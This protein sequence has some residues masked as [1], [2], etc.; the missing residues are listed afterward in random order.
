MDGTNR[1]LRGVLLFVLGVNNEHLRKCYKN[2]NYFIDFYIRMCYIYNYRMLHDMCIKLRGGIG[3]KR[4]L[5]ALF[6]CVLFA[7]VLYACEGVTLPTGITTLVDTTGE[8]T[9]EVS[10]IDVTTISPTTGSP[11]L[12]SDTSIPTT[13]VPTSVPTTDMS[14]ISSDTLEPTTTVP[15]TQAPTTEPVTTVPTTEAPTTEPVTTVPT[16][17]EPTSEPVTTVPTTDAPTTEPVTTIPT[18]EEPTTEPVTTVPTTTIETTQTTDIDEDYASVSF[19]YPNGLLIETIIVLKGEDVTPPSDPQYPETDDYTYTF[20]GWDH[21]MHNVQANLVVYAIY[22]A[23]YKHGSGEFDFNDFLPLLSSISGEN[24]SHEEAQEIVDMILHMTG[25]QSEEHVYHLL[26][27]IPDLRDSLFN[28]TTNEAFQLW[29]ESTK[30]AGFTKELMTDMII[31]AILQSVKDQLDHLPNEELIAMIA[32]LNEGVQYHQLLMDGLLLEVHDYCVTYTSDPDTCIAYYDRYIV[33]HERFIEYQEQMWRYIGDGWIQDYLYFSL[34]PTVEQYIYFTYVDIDPSIAEQRLLSLDAMIDGLPESTQDHYVTLIDMYIAVND[35]YHTN[36]AAIEAQLM[37]EIDTMLPEP[38]PVAERLRD[39]F[40]EHYLPLLEDTLHN[41]QTIEEFESILESLILEAAFLSGTYEWLRSPDGREALREVVNALYDAIDANLLGV[42]EPIYSLI[43][44]LINESF[45]PET[46]FDSET[47]CLYIDELLIILDRFEVAFTQYGLTDIIADAGGSILD[48]FIRSLG[49]EADEQAH[50]IALILPKIPEYLAM[51]DETYHELHQFLESIDVEKVQMAFLVL[52]QMESGELGPFEQVILVSQAIDLILNDGSIDMT[53]IMDY[54]I[55]IYYDVECFFAADAAHVSLVKNAFFSNMTRILELAHDISFYDPLNLSIMEMNAIDEMMSRVSSFMKVFEMGFDYALAPIEFGFQHEDFIELVSNLFGYGMELEEAEY[56]IGMLMEMFEIE[57]E[58]E[59]YYLMVQLANHFMGIEHIT[60]ISDLSSWWTAFQ[61]LGISKADMARYLIRFAQLQFQKD[62]G[63]YGYQMGI[64]QIN[65]WILE[66][67]DQIE[68]I[69]AQIDG[70]DVWINDQ[71]AGFTPEKQELFMSLWNGFIYLTELDIAISNLDRSYY[72]EW[73]DAFDPDRYMTIVWALMDARDGYI[74]WDDF[75]VIW[76]SYSPEEQAL[77]SPILELLDQFHSYLNGTY[78][79]IV[80]AIQEDPDLYVL[81]T[82]DEFQGVKEQVVGLFHQA[83]H[84]QACILEAENEIDY[85]TA[86]I[87][88]STLLLA[89]FS[90]PE[91]QALAEDVILIALDEVEYW[92]ILLDNPTVQII[93][94][95]LL[96]QEKQPGMMGEGGLDWYE[97]DGSPAAIYGYLQDITAVLNG[98]F[99]TIDDDDILKIKTFTFDV[100]AIM[101]VSEGMPQGEV[102]PF[103]AVLEGR[104]DAYWLGFS[105]IQSI[106]TSLLSSVTQDDITW[107]LPQIDALVNGVAHPAERAV[108]I[109]QIID[110][111]LNQK[112]V[113]VL[114]LFGYLVDIYYDITTSM[115]ADPDEVLL[116]KNALDSNLSRILELASLIAALDPSSLPPEAMILLEELSAR[117]MV[118]QAMF[119]HGFHVILEPIEFGYHHDDFLEMVGMLFGGLMEETEM[120]YLVAR[121][122]EVVEKSDEEEAYYLIYAT[123]NHLSRLQTLRSLED[124]FQWVQ[125]IDSLGLTKTDIAH[126]VVNFAVMMFERDLGAYGYSRHIDWIEDSLADSVEQIEAIEAQIAGF[127]DWALSQVD[128]MSIDARDLFMSFWDAYK[129]SVNLDFVMNRVF[130]GYWAE[131]P[132]G[133]DPETYMT[134]YDTYFSTFYDPEIM[135][136][137]DV[138]WAALST[139][140][141]LLYTPLIDAMDATF[142]HYQQVL[143]PLQEAVYEDAELAD[144][145]TS[146]EFANNLQHLRDLY[147]SIS[148]LMNDMVAYEDEIAECEAKIDQITQLWTYFTDPANR[149]LAEEVAV[150]VLDEIDHI[151]TLLDCP[152]AHLFIGFLF[153]AYF[154]PLH[155]MGEGV[156]DDEPFIDWSAPQIFGYLQDVAPILQGL[157]QTIDDDDFALIKTLTLDLLPIFLESEGMEPSDWTDFVATLDDRMD[158]YW[159]AIN[160]MLDN[161]GV[162]LEVLSIEE[163]EVIVTAV[164]IIQDE[165]TSMVEKAIHLSRV[166]DI[167][168]TD[169]TPDVP[170]TIDIELWTSTVLKIY[171][172]T[173][174]ACVYDPL[175]YADLEEV[176]LLHAANLLNYVHAIAAFEIDSITEVE[177]SFIFE[178]IDYIDILMGFDHIEDLY[179]PFEMELGYHHEDFVDLIVMMFEDINDPDEVEDVMAFFMSVFALP[180]NMTYYRLV[181]LVPVFQSAMTIHSVVDAVAWLDV[182]QNQEITSDQLAQLLIFFLVQNLDTLIEMSYEAEDYGYYLTQI[183]DIEAILMQNWIELAYYDAEFARVMDEQTNDLAVQA[184]WDLWNA[185]I[186]LTDASDDYA[187]IENEMRYAPYYDYAFWRQ[188]MTLRFGYDFDQS[189]GNQDLEAFDVLWAS[190]DAEIQELYEPVITALAN[191]IYYRDLYDDAHANMNLHDAELADPVYL[192]GSISY[193][194]GEFVQECSVARRE[195]ALAIHMLLHEKSVMISFLERIEEHLTP[196]KAFQEMLESE[197]GYLLT[198][199]VFKIFMEEMFHLTDMADENA[200]VFLDQMIFDGFE[201]FFVQEDPVALTSEIHHFGAMLNQMFLTTSESDMTVLA[202]G[203]EM[204]LYLYLATF[205]DQAMFDAHFQDLMDITTTY[206]PALP[207]MASQIADMCLD[208]TLDDVLLL[209]SQFQLLSLLP[210]EDETYDMIVIT[211]CV[212]NIIQELVVEDGMDSDFVIETVIGMMFDTRYALGYEDGFTSEDHIDAF[213]LAMADIVLLVP[214][215]SGIDIDDLSSQDMDYINQ[216]ISIVMGLELLFD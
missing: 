19:Y 130:M 18:T 182:V 51:I 64:D 43:T 44:G 147:E 148:A 151:M 49:L 28:V 149:L 155:A 135:D 70:F 178:M 187:V 161:L 213:K 195:I 98:L 142:T 85:M 196:L 16:T 83:N 189:L 2:L 188:L 136:D 105:D 211:V 214:Y 76:G 3:V 112:S 65:Q 79:D 25:I 7:I 128:G 69:E 137:F 9:T 197:D 138:L 63:P 21:D 8:V 93:L 200:W 68:A 114:P 92:L 20:I 199:A 89:Y 96:S 34:L 100:F 27:H 110:T 123:F 154:K 198:E 55:T 173:K 35:Y 145:V 75:D 122:M 206:L 168:L 17:E 109:C 77:Y 202:D 174:Y 179:Y 119:E 99:A 169:L 183:A 164:A 67:G 31:H 52:Q 46:F 184:A 126:Y 193:Y 129:L 45:D 156:P 167:F 194:F 153:D 57:D 192:S 37:D 204:Y 191:Y 88:Q 50:L 82:N 15:T 23:H 11:T 10:T 22:E 215:L 91:K 172:D 86:R 107:L 201:Y 212:A 163:V 141:Q 6:F 47:I 59:A 1:D 186:L 29:Y 38:M 71:L 166:I 175:D 41:L 74:S 176:I 13:F 152:T 121:L 143:V 62:T 12:D 203:I 216:F 101:M 120:E 181:L 94:D 157:L 140:E 80:S 113:D 190:M 118:L 78:Q 159:L 111:F 58:E 115:T 144:M 180:E 139:E 210:S 102:D 53:L 150:I 185:F 60:S 131:W 208:L 5:A 73:Q 26:L 40:Y 4:R 66:C 90:D 162:T 33:Y 39:H 108:I 84:Y 54:V 177:I 132:E 87:A 42:S 170:D 14:S 205:W 165:D 160:D 81:M 56:Y 32:D 117:V 72:D 36:I 24:V 116:I 48:I 134:L 171:F 61:G 146:W 127:D 124:I 103:I 209:R 97:I 106:L 207:D 30:T 125:G 158:F 104:F 95:F 133:F